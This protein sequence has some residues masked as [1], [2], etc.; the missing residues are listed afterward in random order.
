MTNL[1]EFLLEQIAKDEA[2]ARDAHAGP[3]WYNTPLPK[4]RHVCRVVESGP[5]NG[6]VIERCACGAIRPADW[7][8][9]EWIERNSRR[10]I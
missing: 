4:V 6:S 8:N 3:H 7:P 9:G 10:R 5:V 2:A 1:K